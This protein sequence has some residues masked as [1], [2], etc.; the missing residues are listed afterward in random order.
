VT[1][2]SQQ[3]SYAKR[4][5]RRRAAA[6]TF[7][8]L[9]CAVLGAAPTQVR[10]ADSCL[11]LLCFAAPS[12]RAIPQCV[13]PVRQVLRDLA[14]GRAFPTCTMSSGDSAGSHT[15]ASAPN[16]CPPQ[17]TRSADGESQTLYSCDF[18]GAV[19]VTVNGVP[20]SRTWWSFSGVTVTEFS[21]DAKRQLGTWDT[22]FD[23]DFAAW[24]LAVQAA[25][26]QPAQPESF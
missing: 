26:Q 8:A 24:M 19:S 15:W 22:R 10:A 17:Y 9:L 5:T 18:D 3:R 23:D 14:R 4:T 21:A 16:F 11:I 25:A 13:A 6:F 2:S 20:F 1:V 12:W 7:S